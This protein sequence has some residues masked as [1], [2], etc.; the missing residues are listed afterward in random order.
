M[1]YPNPTNNVINISGINISSGEFRIEA[2]N[3]LGQKLEEKRILSLNDSLDS[4]LD[5]SGYASGIYTI[6]VYCETY[7][8]VFKVYK[9]E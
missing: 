9:I 4:Y 5:M 2:Y 3:V 7:R 8:Q 6:V 1:V